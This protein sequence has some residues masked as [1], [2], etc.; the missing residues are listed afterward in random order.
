MKDIKGEGRSDLQ[1]HGTTDS[2]VFDGNI[3]FYKSSMTVKNL[4]TKI[5]DVTLEMPV[6]NSRIL[7]QNF[8]LPTTT[9]NF[10]V[11]GFINISDLENPTFQ[12]KAEPSD[13]KLPALNLNF[14]TPDLQISGNILIKELLLS[15]TKSLIQLSGN[16]QMENCKITVPLSPSDTAANISGMDVIWNLPITIGNS[17]S[18]STPVNQFILKKDST[19][20]EKA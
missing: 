8:L 7:L 3:R 18:F 19:L 17:V 12:I 15:G 6:T 20:G 2:P 13:K 11:N 10:L 14:N 4:N 9:G 5:K 1:F 16:M